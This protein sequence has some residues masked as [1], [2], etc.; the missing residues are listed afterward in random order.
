MRNTY[1]P[2]IQTADGEF[3]PITHMDAYSSLTKQNRKYWN[4]KTKAIKTFHIFAFRRKYL[5]GGYR[6][7]INK[8]RKNFRC[9]FST[10]GKFIFRCNNSKLTET[11]SYF[12]Q[13][14]CRPSYVKKNLKTANRFIVFTFYF[15]WI[16]RVFPKWSRILMWV[17][18]HT[19]LWHLS[20]N[21]CVFFL[22]IKKTCLYV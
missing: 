13:L 3:I 19:I 17:I 10:F 15:P 9:H 8:Y 16:Y 6:R 20:V 2:N 1:T 11:V 7:S 18:R 12:I 5:R 22:F 21:F 4:G 14:G